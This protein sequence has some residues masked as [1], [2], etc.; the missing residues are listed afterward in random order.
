MKDE[1]RNKFDMA[2]DLN[3]VFMKTGSNYLLNQDS[4]RDKII[5]EDELS[6]TQ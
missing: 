2:C 6:G 1:R 3:P 4:A 5:E